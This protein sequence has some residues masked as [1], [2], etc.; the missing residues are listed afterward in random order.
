MVRAHGLDDP[1]QVVLVDNLIGLEVER[2]LSRTGRQRDVGLLG[3]DQPVF[4]QGFIPHRL[5]DPD[6][7]IADGPDQFKRAVLT[8]SYVDDELVDDRQDGPDG[9]HDRIVITHRV[10][11]K[12]ESADLHAFPISI[13]SV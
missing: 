4:S 11:A 8:A 7:G 1:W 3:I 2:P 9:L 6:L 10:A 12:G 13:N 5:D